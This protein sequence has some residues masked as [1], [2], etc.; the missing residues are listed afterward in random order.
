MR[1]EYF[2]PYTS[3]DKRISKSA[4]HEDLWIVDI[5]GKNKFYTVH[6]S[7]QL[8]LQNNPPDSSEDTSKRHFIVA[9]YS[10]NEVAILSTISHHAPSLTS[11]RIQS[12]RKNISNSPKGLAD[13]Q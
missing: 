4:H 3:K 7:T 8:M 6:M 12:I 10:R 13:I 2:K 1:K 5:L 9:D 11:G